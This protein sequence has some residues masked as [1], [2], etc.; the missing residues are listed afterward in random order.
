MRNWLQDKYVVLTGASGG[1]GR[2]LA[3]L[4]VKKY[5][6]K[7]IGVGRSE[8]KMQSLKTELGEQADDFSYRLFDVGD[9]MAWTLFGEELKTKGIFPALLINNAGIFP[10]FSKVLQ[11]SVETVERV[12][13]VNYLSVVYATKTLSPILRGDGKDKPAIVNV[14]SSSALCTVVGAAAYSASKAAIKGYTEALQLEETGKKYVGIVYPGTTAT[15]L[16]RDDKNTK[17]SALDYIAMPAEKMAKK[18]ARK[19]LKKKK[20]AVLG[21]DAK[22]MALTAKLAP[23]KGLALIRGVMKLSRSKVFAEVFGYGKKEK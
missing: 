23:V 18:I 11:G 14:S 16:F 20:R 6:A 17:N 22:L 5:G 7:V 21:W 12:M 13:Q 10:P 15:D 3:K 1:I 19:I 4:L 8:E 2:E 9:K